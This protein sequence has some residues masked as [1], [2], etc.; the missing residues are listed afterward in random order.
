MCHHVN[1][2]PIAQ[3]ERGVLY[4]L[5]FMGVCVLFIDPS[6]PS[7]ATTIKTVTENSP[8]VK[9]PLAGNLRTQ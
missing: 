7:E 9:M 8:H 5:L 4:V 6:D 2:C 3:E 1:W